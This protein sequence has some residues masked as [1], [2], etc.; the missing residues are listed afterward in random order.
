MPFITA[1]PWWVYALFFY[2][3]FIGIKALK[4]DIK[5]ISVCLIMPVIFTGMSVDNIIMLPYLNLWYTIAFYIGSLIIVGSSI[6]FILAKKIGVS[7]DKDHQLIQLPGSWFTLISILLIFIIKYYFHYK[8]EV[9]PK[10]IDIEYHFIIASGIITGLFIGRV[11]YYF[12]RLKQ[13]PWVNLK[14]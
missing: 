1:T 2:L 4:D 14:T 11:S 12:L 8:M 5:P 9:N 6:G 3:M 10:Q 13:G 7:V